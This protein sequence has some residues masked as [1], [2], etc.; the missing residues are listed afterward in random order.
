[1]RW[2][3]AV[4]SRFQAGTGH[5]SGMQGAGWSAIRNPAA[6]GSRGCSIGVFREGKMEIPGTSRTFTTASNTV[7]RKLWLAPRGGRPPAAERATGRH[8]EPPL[9]P[10]RTA[11]HVRT[12]RQGLRTR[13]RPATTPQ[14]L[15][16]ESAH[17]APH[18]V[19]RPRARAGDRD[20]SDSRVPGLSTETGGV[21][22]HGQS[23]DHRAGTHVSDRVAARPTESNA[24]VPA[25]VGREPPEAGVFR[26]CRIQCDPIPPAAA[27][28][29]R[30]G[31]CV[32]LRLAPSRN[33]RADLGRGRPGRRRHST[34]SGAIQNETE[35]GA[36]AGSAAPRR[37]EA[38]P[39]APTSR[40][41]AGVP[42]GGPPDWRLAETVAPGL[43]TRR[44][45]RQTPARLSAHGRPKLDPGWR[46]GTRRH[47]VDRPQDPERVRPLQH[48]ERARSDGRGRS[49][50]QLR[51][52]AER[53]AVCRTVHAGA[54]ERDTIA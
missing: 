39:H 24:G 29:R 20:R 6:A 5:G 47:D 4:S 50:R 38:S 51:R 54:G 35:S 23:G 13:L 46:A 52:T 21:R 32:L 36:P 28:S 19:L 9:H 8:R 49:A 37:P 27:L 40:H 1:M 25:T 11:I 48:R 33:P 45:A 42:L 53:A 12:P 26:T 15:D 17:R 14:S 31:L 43:S 10:P 44:A 2:N 22:R 3:R 7:E 34:G 30:A 18:D 16:G 41:R